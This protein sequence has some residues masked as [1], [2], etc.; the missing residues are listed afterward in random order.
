[1]ALKLKTGLLDLLFP[2]LCIACR[3]PLGAGQ[4][5]CADCWGAIAFLDG[6]MCECCGLPFGIDPGEAARCAACL[7]RPPAYD[8]ARAIFVYDENSRG[9]ILALK[10]S[11]RLELVPGFA[12]WL[13]RTGRPLL[14]ETDLIV[15]VPL[16]RL[17]LWRR[18][19]NQAAELARAL[20][21][22]T[23]KPIAVRALER[24]RP[25]E[26]QGA[27]ASAGS[28]RRN[29]RGAFRVAEPA[30]V[31]G[32]NILIVDD[33]LTTGATAEACAQ[34]LKRAGAKTVQILALARVAKASEV[35]P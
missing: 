10:H 27:M 31:A 4:G 9:P 29:V 5:F 26:S 22:R 18:R 11:D 28:R 19:Y 16:H 14:A 20:A 3:E 15:P 7:A 2:P 6:P 1:M 32:R 30:L 12:H 21:R 8:R 17:R 23:A 34:A 24:S 33:V 35:L 13:E 25:T